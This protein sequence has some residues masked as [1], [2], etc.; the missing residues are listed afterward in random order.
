MKPAIDRPAQEIE[1]HIR[2]ERISQVYRNTLLAQV[3]LVALAL[4]T[5]LALSGEAGAGGIGVW[6]AAMVVVGLGRA[7]AGW[8]FRHHDPATLDVRFW[9]RVALVGTTLAGLGW[10]ALSVLFLPHLRLEHQTLI[11]LILAGV[12]AGAV[13]V[14]AAELFLYL[15]YA[16]MVLVP[17]MAVLLIQGSSLAYF[18]ALATLL[19]FFTLARSAAYLNRLIVENLRER[20]AKESALAEA[21]LAN[22][23][24]REEI[25][26]RKRIE[27]D[28][29]AAR[30]AAEAANRAKSEF[31][32]N[33]SHEIRTPMNGI[34]GM[35]GLA[36]DTPLTDR[37]RNYL[38]T[39]MTSAQSM[40]AM[41]TKLLDFARLGG[42]E[43]KLVKS[44]VAPEALLVQAVRH[45]AMEAKA[46]G[47]TLQVAGAP[48]LPE[49]LDIDPEPIVQVFELLIENAIKFTP[50]GTVDVRL[51]RA[52]RPGWLRF[53]VADTGIGIPEDKRVVIFE[54][55]QQA[56]GSST[57]AHGGLGIG[58]SLAAELASLVGGELA[59]ESL[60]GQGSTF[61]FDFP[62]EER[63]A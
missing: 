22:A 45:L 43:V 26:R 21:R 15:V 7:W 29:I 17:L 56:D 25:E 61:Y 37:Q 50:S 40:M 8:R 35:T 5:T 18:F 27:H 38:E 28:L 3:M 48:D 54:A 39:V 63:A 4:I 34:I 14:L 60:V 11:L 55:F 36:L 31:L 24:L 6:L 52:Q 62:L 33:A 57:R 42:G 59:V 41:L 51:A 46:K 10:A 30:D 2:A 53:S 9:Q 32:A 1:A 16:V 20:F 23:S 13:P 58:L 47:L 49:R 44:Q 12:V 19:F